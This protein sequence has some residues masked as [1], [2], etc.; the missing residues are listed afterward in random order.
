MPGLMRN[1]LLR[2]LPQTYDFS[3]N[4]PTIPLSLMES[5]LRPGDCGLVP[6]GGDKFRLEGNII[7]FATGVGL[8]PIQDDICSP[9]PLDLQFDDSPVSLT[10]PDAECLNFPRLDLYDVTS[11]SLPANQR[12]VSLL[13]TLSFRL[14]GR[15]L[16]TRV[17]RCSDRC[18]LRPAL[19]FTSTSWG[20]L[21]LDAWQTLDTPTPLYSVMVPL[22]WCQIDLDKE[23][24]TMLLKIIDNFSVLVGW[25]Q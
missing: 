3:E 23:L 21:G 16:V 22:A 24:M 19:D 10:H 14:S 9:H 5:E 18:Y 15:L 13:K 20:I 17:I 25:S 7:E 12:V 8:D 11:W 1:S 6:Q 2:K 4:Y